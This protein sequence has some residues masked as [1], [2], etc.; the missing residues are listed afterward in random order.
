VLSASFIPVY[1]R[2][3]A[4][5]KHEEAR[6]VAGA[7]FGLL[8]VVAA[9]I[10]LLGVLLAEPL[11]LLLAP[12]FRGRPETFDLTVSLVRI[13]FPAVGLLVLSA[14]CLGVLNSH[15]RFFL[16]YVA[17][18]GLNVVQI[19]VLV[20]GGLALLSGGLAPGQTDADAQARLVTWLAVGTVVGGGLQFLVQL[21]T[22]RRVA[23]GVRPS[24]RTDLPGV[25]QTLRAF[26]PVVAGRGVV[27]ISGY[28]QLVLASF[29]AA[30]A[31]A[32]LRYAQVLY[33]LPVSLFGMAVAAAELPELSSAGTEQRATVARRLQSGLTRIAVFVVPTSVGYLVVG[34][35]I[36]AALFQT[37]A[38]G[39]LESLAVWLVLAGFTV[40]LLAT[41]SSR[42]LQ[43]ALYGT[44]NT[45]T[46]AWAAALR[47]A[48]SLGLGVLLML[49][50][51]RVAIT[52]DGLRL[53]GDL[54][55]LTPLPE[56][57]RAAAAD[58]RL[59]RL[60]AAGLA[61][62][63]GAAAWLEYLLLRRAVRRDL[64]PTSLGGGQLGPIVLA[65]L[66]GGAAASSVRL[67]ADALPPE[68]SGPLAALVLA[69]V[70]AAVASALGVTE[71][72]AVLAGLRRRL[73]GGC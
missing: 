61:L 68:V 44:G 45:R 46:P 58:E 38:F 70:Y 55:A 48:V 37:G 32:T 60:G 34:D 62:A 16:S 42:L 50:L 10:S 56:A 66:V 54:P 53:L 43:S 24:L 19:G 69:A 47:V 41:T 6:R 22:V 28:L 29:L 57:A 26:G 51:D 1:S 25:R 3:L 15:R 65:A 11:T 7:V 12:G 59:L 17:P 52:P 14:W 30:G 2:L 27:Q 33:L 4:E 20:G 5:G 31:L 72:R 21:P 63:A 36:T 67:V 35:L 18:V 40:G 49:Q 23:S 64:V 8:A 73:P 71:V 39:R 13:L 9:L